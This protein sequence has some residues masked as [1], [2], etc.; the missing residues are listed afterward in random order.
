MSILIA[1]FK[2]EADADFVAQFIRKVRG[3]AKVL[4]E[5]ELENQWMIKMID[6]AENEGGEVPEEEIVK[7]LK[8][9]GAKI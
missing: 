7:I 9:N 2:N 3:K 8:Q 6:E 5:D 4:N 1:K